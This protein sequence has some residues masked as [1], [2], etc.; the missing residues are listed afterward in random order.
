MKNFDKIIDEHRVAAKDC[1]TVFKLW[2]MAREFVIQDF[3]GTM[4]AEESACLGSV[5]LV[6]GFITAAGNSWEAHLEAIQA[7][8][9]KPTGFEDFFRRYRPEMWA[10]LEKQDERLSLAHWM[11]RLRLDPAFPVRIMTSKDDFLN[12]GLHWE[13]FKAD[14][15]HPTVDVLMMDWGGHSGPIAMKQFK[16]I[17]RETLLRQ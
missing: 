12:F 14:A 2:L 16:D 3:P 10:L 13:A 1:S 15:Q 5:A 6:D 9:P 11:R 7:E 4:S 17:L 8:G